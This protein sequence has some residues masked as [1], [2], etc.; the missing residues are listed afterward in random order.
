MPGLKGLARRLLWQSSTRHRVRPRPRRSR[1]ATEGPPMTTTHVS[2]QT[3]KK[4]PALSHA[5]YVRFLPLVRRIAMRLARRLPSHIE[6]D[7]LLSLGWV[8]LSEAISRAPVTISAEEFEAYASQRVKGS[9]RDYL[10]SLDPNARAVRNTAR[11]N[12]RARAAGDTAASEAPCVKFEHVDVDVENPAANDLP[13]DELVSRAML[14]SK[15]AK[16]VETMSKREQLV[17]SLYYRDECT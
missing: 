17:L 4:T 11:R 9:M 1:V 10:R 16:T 15:V 2:A 7:D 12:A 6:L 14:S 3:A 8:G 5:D 13:A